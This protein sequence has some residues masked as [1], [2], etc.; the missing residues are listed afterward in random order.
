MFRTI[1]DNQY[2]LPEEL[3]RWLGHDLIL[4]ELTRDRGLPTVKDYID[5]NWGGDLPDEIDAEDAEVL[6]AIARFEASLKE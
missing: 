5:I 6:E 3:E 2:K 1:N 4:Q